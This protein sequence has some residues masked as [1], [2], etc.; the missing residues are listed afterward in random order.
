MLF[1]PIGLDDM[2][3]GRMPTLSI[4]IAVVCLVVFMFTLEI[5]GHGLD[6]ALVPA[7]GVMQ[8]GWLAYMFL[9][10]GWG[11]LLGNFLFLYVSAP[12]IEDAW[13]AARF[14]A[15]YLVGGIVA[16]LG[17]AVLDPSSTVP[18]I[19]A[20]G[21]VAACMGAL[22]VQFP[23]RRV[24]IF[25][26]FIRFAGT[27]F[28]P[29]WLWG[30][31]WFAKELLDFALFGA[32]GGVALGAHL[33]GFAFGALMAFVIIKLQ[34]DPF[35]A[36]Y[37][38]PTLETTP[39]PLPALGTVPPRTSMPIPDIAATS[40]APSPPAPIVGSEVDTAPRTDPVDVVSKPEQQGTIPVVPQAFPKKPKLKRAPVSTD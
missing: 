22:C 37:G 39:A 6:W 3:V 10:A 9:H 16:G 36:R 18:I 34:G 5:E 14:L 31:L 33:A 1:V 27:F 24:R 2:K 20:S 25:Y 13:G 17:Q 12:Y 38:S 11:H 23:R 4:G 8:P 26:W 29:V 40:P 15:L 35:E 32:H 30:G 21:A 19:G 28:L 7:Q